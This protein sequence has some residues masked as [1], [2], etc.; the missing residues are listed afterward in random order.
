[1]P[2]VLGA[3]RERAAALSAWLASH[4]P[5]PTSQIPRDA[6]SGGR[7]VHARGAMPMRARAS[8]T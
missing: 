2:R 8:P 3:L 7:F 1:V 6:F 5:V 4:A